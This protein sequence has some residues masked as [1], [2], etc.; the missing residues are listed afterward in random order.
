MKIRTEAQAKAELITLLQNAYSGELAA[1]YAY[2]GHQK[3]VSDLQE[4][5]DITRIR[6]EEWE[7]RECVGNM[8]KSLG[9][10]PRK[11]REILMSMIGLSIGFMCRIG[12]WLIPMHGAGK[13]ESGN[14]LE[15][16]IAAELA[17]Q[18][19]SHELIE[20]L[21][22]MAEI[23]WD[24]EIYFREKFLS[25]RFH[26]LLPLWEIPLPREAIRKKFEIEVQKM[27]LDILNA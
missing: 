7:H 14:I 23:E 9:A 3:S 21:L 20:P 8:L 19:G 27:D 16:E 1:Y 15:Y 24:H 22:Q 6:D 18:A 13:L 5:T 11:S 10:G 4:K 26:Y 25:H 17:K 12:G 2:D